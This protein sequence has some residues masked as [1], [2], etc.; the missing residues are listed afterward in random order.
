MDDAFIT[1]R[2]AE[3]LLS[4][5]GLVFHPGER[6]LGTTTPLYAL[7]CASAGALRLPL[8]VTMPLLNIGIELML[9]RQ[10]WR[11]ALATLPQRLLFAALLI[12]SPLAARLCANG[13][14]TELFMLLVVQSLIWTHRQHYSRA[15]ALAALTCLCRPEALI[16]LPLV[17]GAALWRRRLHAAMAS[18]AVAAALL[19]SIA[20]ALHSYYGHVL[21]LSMRLKAFSIG[22]SRA[23]ALALFFAFD[24]V[25]L[26]ASVLAAIGLRRIRSFTGVQALTCLFGGVYML[27]YLMAA[28]TMSLWYAYPALIAIMLCAA[29]AAHPLPAL[30]PAVTASSFVF[31][32][33]VYPRISDA[34]GIRTHLYGDMRQWCEATQ[35]QSIMACDVGRIGYYCRNSYIYDICGLVWERIAE[36][37]QARTPLAGVL[38]ET[39]PEYLLLNPIA[40]YMDAMRG[41][42]GYTLQR[43]FAADGNPEAAIGEEYTQDYKLEYYLFKR[44]EP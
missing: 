12:A 8:E 7:L 32:L 10:L 41:Q 35:P 11:Y 19:T 24:P 34:E 37:Y 17:V 20:L 42:Q 25:S 15:A 36:K 23:E 2:Y 13:M 18:A 43:R 40:S 29:Q 3:N 30:L 14:E 1:Y 27:A 28:P 6:V 38:A 31:W 22:G 5:H 39:R 33:A 44:N 4:G 21:P 26:L 16:L 9:L